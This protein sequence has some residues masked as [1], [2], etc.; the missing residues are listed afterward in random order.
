MTGLFSGA[1]K[2]QTPL[3]WICC[4]FVACNKL[5]NKS[6]TNWKSTANPQ[7]VVQHRVHRNIEGLQQI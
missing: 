3:D 1:D 4:G 5:C 2:A 6:T 7:Q